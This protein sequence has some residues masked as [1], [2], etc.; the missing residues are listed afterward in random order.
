MPFAQTKTFL[1]CK[2]PFLKKIFFLLIIFLI[3]KSI[4]TATAADG[5]DIYP[6]DSE[7]ESGGGRETRIAAVFLQKSGVM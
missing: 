6:S 1:H 4:F 3:F 2:N 5:S 7:R